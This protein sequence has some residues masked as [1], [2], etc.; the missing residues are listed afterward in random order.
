MLVKVVPNKR[1]QFTPPHCLCIKSQRVELTDAEKAING[2]SRTFHTVTYTEVQNKGLV[3]QKFVNEQGVEI[4]PSV[5]SE[6]KEVGSEGIFNSSRP[7]WT[8]R[9]KRYT[10]KEQDKQRYY[11]DCER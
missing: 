10:F 11:R 8:L 7:I 9:N 4:A 6:L 5:K 2:V 3:T 1:N